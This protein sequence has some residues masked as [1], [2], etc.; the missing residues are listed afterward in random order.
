MYIALYV[1]ILN[2]S[3]LECLIKP[4]LCKWNMIW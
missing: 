2:N 4:T 3:F 1:N